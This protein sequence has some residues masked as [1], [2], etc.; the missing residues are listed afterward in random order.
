MLRARVTPPQVL[1]KYPPSSCQ[2]LLV[3]L[4]PGHVGDTASPFNRAFSVLLD[5][6][7]T[8]L[9]VRNRPSWAL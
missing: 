7:N 2:V 9:K 1:L 5:T 3:P 6:N 4:S 8:N